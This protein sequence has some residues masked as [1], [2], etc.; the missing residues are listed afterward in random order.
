MPANSRPFRGARHRY[1]LRTHSIMGE[2]VDPTAKRPP[3]VG[4]SAVWRVLGNACLLVFASLAV[5]SVATG[6]IA[7]AML[8]AGALLV[9]FAPALDRLAADGV[10]ASRWF[11]HRANGLRWCGLALAASGAALLLA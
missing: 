10:R 8:W 9:F 11:A 1:C 7:A 4:R 6:R 2:P 5:I 3:R